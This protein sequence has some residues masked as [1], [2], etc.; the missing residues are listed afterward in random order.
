M[1][2][3]RDAANNMLM[4]ERC[5]RRYCAVPVTRTHGTQKCAWANT[6]C[7]TSC[8]SKV[9]HHPV[10][11]LLRPVDRCIWS[12]T[13]LE[14]PS[15]RLLHPEP[16]HLRPPGFAPDC[17][18]LSM[19]F[20]CASHTTVPNALAKSPWLVLTADVSARARG[21]GHTAHIYCTCGWDPYPPGQSLLETLNVDT[22][23]QDVDSLS[24]RHTYTTEVCSVVPCLHMVV[25]TPALCK[26]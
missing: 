21:G 4:R 1:R 3:H 7:S 8:S 12:T 13:I 22:S 9:Q 23:L 25:L 10:H 26:G 14:K 18:H 6:C 20:C 15:T 2:P 11:R 24:I 16:I 19:M 17:L 5:F